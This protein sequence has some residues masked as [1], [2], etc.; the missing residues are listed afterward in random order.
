MLTHAEVAPLIQ[1]IGQGTR[2][3]NASDLEH[4][5]ECLLSY[6]TAVPNELSP[7]D[8]ALL[9]QLSVQ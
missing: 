2:Q 8:V 9:E 6:L 7:A 3:H 5:F 4:A 1:L